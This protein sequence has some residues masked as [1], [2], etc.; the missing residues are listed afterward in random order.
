MA[1]EK[2]ADAMKDCSSV[3][4]DYAKM[5][6]MAEEFKNPK[7]FAWHIAGDIWHNR[8][9]ITK[10]IKTAVSD[11][12]KKKWYDFG[13]QVGEAAEHV[14]IGQMTQMLIKK[15]NMAKFTKGYYAKFGG[16]FD[17]E[18]LLFC[19]YDEDQAALMLDVAY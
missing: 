4:G 8:V 5:K 3:K 10:E 19:I 13:L 11:Y 14:F 18:A 17:I 15:E 2:T 9:E 6:K 12:E 1:I 16:N 7:Q